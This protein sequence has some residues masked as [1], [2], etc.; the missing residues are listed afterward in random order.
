MYMIIEGVEFLVRGL[1]DFTEKEGKNYLKYI[2]E[3]A[4]GFDDS[5]KISEVWV[6]S[7]DD[8]KVD[9]YYK[10]LGSKFERIRRITGYLVGT[11]DR[12]NNSKQ[13]EE[14]ERVKHGVVDYE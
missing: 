11:L 7:C 5:M 9:L 13:A 4:E 10:L 1:K 6:S 14:S 12:W 3:N 2:K 8:G